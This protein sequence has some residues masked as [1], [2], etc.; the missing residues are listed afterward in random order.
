M[1]TLPDESAASGRLRRLLEQLWARLD[2][3][4][5]SAPATLMLSAEL[6]I[7]TPHGPLRLGL[8]SDGHR[9]LLVPI[10]PDQRLETD[11][12]SA[13]VHLTDRVLLAEDAPVRFADLSCRRPDLNEIFTGLVADVCTRIATEPDS[14]PSRIAQTL[15]SWRLLLSGQA[16][17]WTPQRMAGLFAELTVLERLLRLS[18]AAAVAWLG[19]TG[20]A[21]DF[22]ARDT[23]LEVKASLA[24]EGRTIRVH[25]INQL[26]TPET[27]SLSLSWFRVVE[28]SVRSAQS[29]TDIMTSCRSRTNSPAVLDERLQSIGIGTE[30]PPILSDVRFEITDERWY[31]VDDSFP[32]IVP[33]TFENG[34]SPAGVS[35]LEYL[36][37]LNTVRADTDG[38]TVLNNL[39]G[40]L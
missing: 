38:F 27:G 32:K 33:T 4:S 1:N 31:S 22:R 8:D 34:T 5:R 37:D 3:E 26:E 9:H 12:R 17:R 39:V 28:S 30:S 35:G 20:C 16:A 10:A 14:G 2:V 25:G 6:K 18:P 40:H 36:V 11:R 7:D 29:I 23:C 15:S 13:G 19:P 24:T 21:Q